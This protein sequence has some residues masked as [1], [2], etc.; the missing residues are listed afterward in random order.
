M[1]HV[2][3]MLKASGDWLSKR[4]GVCVLVFACMCIRGGEG[5]RSRHY[6]RAN[7]KDSCF[8]AGPAHKPGQP[9]QSPSATRLTIS[10]G[11]IFYGNSGETA[12][13]ASCHPFAKDLT[14]SL[15]RMLP[16][17]VKVLRESMCVNHGLSPAGLYTS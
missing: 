1:C 11:F 17:G 16:K 5:G 14:L 12:N 2:H 7:E 3:K 15:Y 10:H 6:S 8:L 9:A 13:P 4:Q